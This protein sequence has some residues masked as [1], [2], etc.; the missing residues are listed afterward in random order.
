M[1]AQVVLLRDGKILLAR[2]ERVNSC[3]W[4][5]PGGAVEAG[6]S[7]EDAAKREL[8]EE[9]GLSV[10]LLR[11]LFIDG[12]RECGAISI[13]K[14]R[15]TY[16]GEIVGGELI[17]PREAGR[18]NPGNGRLTQVEWM[19][20]DSPEFDEATRDTLSLV[21]GALGADHASSGA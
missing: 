13:K 8:R 18:G 14:P 4:V 20:L 2:H 3:Y 6:E 16:L 15:Y 17:A 19:P 9:S 21:R 5:L 12:P 10:R 1:R 11:L 7:T